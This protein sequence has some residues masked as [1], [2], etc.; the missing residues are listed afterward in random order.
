MRTACREHDDTIIPKRRQQHHSYD[1]SVEESAKLIE[2]EPV[3]VERELP[4]EE[5][6][7]VEALDDE[8]ALDVPAC[9]G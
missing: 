2:D 4:A 6:E 7:P 5:N 3:E 8:S 9:D 1:E